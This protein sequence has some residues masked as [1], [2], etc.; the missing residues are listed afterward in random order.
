MYSIAQGVSHA[1]RTAPAGRRTPRGPR[2]H[3]PPPDF[4]GGGVRH[5]RGRRLFHGKCGLRS[6]SSSAGPPPR[7]SHRMA[8]V[9]P[10][11]RSNNPQ[12]VGGG[13]R[14]WRGR[15][16][17]RLRSNRA[18]LCLGRRRLGT[19]SGPLAG[20]SAVAGGRRIVG[21]RPGPSLSRCCGGLVVR[22]ASGP[23]RFSPLAT[24]SR[25]GANA[26]ALLPAEFFARSTFVGSSATPRRT[27][28]GHDSHGALFARRS[29]SRSP[30]ACWSFACFGT[31]R[32]SWG[33]ARKNQP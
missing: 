33:S 26:G 19:S 16:D 13:V 11:Q 25:R 21:A 28:T 24:R 32:Y 7:H 22:Q 31:R 5:R 17:C 30:R 2:S 14:G 29:G 1:S 10:R 27:A 4:G 15:V 23:T 18:V 12:P 20:G 9:L 3:S 6:H 8:V